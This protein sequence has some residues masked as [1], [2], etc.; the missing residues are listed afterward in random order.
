VNFIDEFLKKESSAG[1]LLIVATIFA[2]LLKNSMFSDFYAA[3]LRTPVEIHFASL[4]IAKPLL[5]WINDGLMASFF[6]ADR[7]GGQT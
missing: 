6:P 3:F 4:H 1:I 5:L 2:L 7:A